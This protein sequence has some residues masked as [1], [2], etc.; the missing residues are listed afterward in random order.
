MR[1]RVIPA[2]LTLVIGAGGGA[3][4]AAAVLAA[5]PAVEAQPAFATPTTAPMPVVASGTEVIADLVDRVGPAV[6]NID[7][8]SERRVPAYSFNPF[9]LDDFFNGQPMQQ[10]QRIVQQKG[11]GS[12]FVVRPDGLIVTNNH[13]VAGA[14]ELS[15]T[16]PDGRKFKG[17]L[18]GT[19]PGS[20]LALVKVEAK[21]LPALKL[22]DPKSLR[23]GQWTVAIGSPLGLSHSVTAGILSAMDREVSLNNRVG[24]LQTST[25]INPGNSG[26]PLLNMKGEVIGVNTA[27]AAHAQGIGFAV[28]V[29]TVSRIIPQLEAKGKVERAWLGV[30]LKDLPDNRQAMFYPV[31]AGVIVAQVD[32]RGPAAKAGLTTGDVVQALNGK[33]VKNAHDLIVAVGTLKVGEKVSLLVNREGQKKTLDVTLGQMPQRVAN[34]AQEQQQPMEAQP[35]DGE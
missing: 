9:S 28:P 19:D 10:R 27:V 23:V 34:A 21:D 3:I 18:I 6:V 2:A 14:T 4:G 13:V 7:T 33:P 29:D 31:D 20:D 24:F 30:G 12:G 22:A 25:P 35:D 26:G 11:V 32:P 15:V 5:K 17:K 8:V 1:M 16:L